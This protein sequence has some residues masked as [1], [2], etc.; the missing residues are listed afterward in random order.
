MAILKSDFAGIVGDDTINYWQWLAE[1]E[2]R[3]ISIQEVDIL[4][5]GNGNDRPAIKP[6]APILVVGEVLFDVFADSRVI[7]G[8]PFN[9]ACQ[10][11]SLGFETCFASAVG[12]DTEGREILEF[13]ASKGMQT[14]GVKRDH[15]RKTGEVIVTLDG[16]GVPEY[17]ILEDRAW[18]R[19]GLTPAVESLLDG[20]IALVCYG[21]LA[22]RSALSREAIGRILDRIGPDTVK[23]CDLNLRQHYYSRSLVEQCVRNADI[24]KLNEDELEVV[25]EL[26]DYDGEDFAG[27]LIE[28][29]SLLCLCVTLGAKGSRLYLPDDRSIEHAIGK[30]RLPGDLKD[31]VGAGDAFTAMLCAGFLKRHS[32]SDVVNRA[33]R[34]AA[35]LCTVRGALP[36]GEDFYTSFINEL[37]FGEM[38]GRGS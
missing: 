33:S 38:K 12:N 28:A 27:H 26:F 35:A 30:N 37:D 6:T 14:D 15:E 36:E 5:N 13:M 8:A 32:W 21:S 4:M 19:I 1:G 34:F 18:D 31:T 2:K 10:L 9:F 7:G 29:Y 25:K 17:D 24:L 20:E 11:H 16:D 22:Q 3:R 23:V